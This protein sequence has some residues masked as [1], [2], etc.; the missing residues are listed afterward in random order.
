MKKIK[1][2]RGIN[3]GFCIRINNDKIYITSFGYSHLFNYPSV[4][5]KEVSELAK[6][7]D[8]NEIEVYFDLSSV[9]GENASNKYFVILYDKNKKDF[10]YPSKKTITFKSGV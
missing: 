3:N 7:I 9:L 2:N 6:L 5:I 1:F 10:I 4:I 8:K